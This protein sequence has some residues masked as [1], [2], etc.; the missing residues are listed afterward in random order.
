MNSTSRQ[1]CASAGFAHHGA[2]LRARAARGS[3]ALLLAAALA[4]CA[5][6]PPRA[7]DQSIVGRL[8][9]QV[10][11][12]DTDAARLFS[13]GF[14]L[15]GEPEAGQLDL[16]A[17]T[18]TVVAR[19]VWRPGSA[20]LDIGQGPAR[21]AN[22]A[23]LTRRALGEQLPME[24]LFDW[25]QGRPWPALPHQAMAKGF[26]QAGWQVDTSGLARGAVVAKRDSRPVV[27]LRLRVEPAP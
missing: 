5:S 6:T 16:F 14:E 13:A 2:A 1:P 15:R 26:E 17:P 9:L 20:Q 22:L 8:V 10:S 12:T 11:A 3:A 23:D 25:L 18:G 7:S 19:A 21:Y 27:T 24:A 4:G